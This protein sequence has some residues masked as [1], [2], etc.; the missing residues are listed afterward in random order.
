MSYIFWVWILLSQNSENGESK[1][2]TF[3]LLNNFQKVFRLKIVIYVMM[4]HCFLFLK[5]LKLYGI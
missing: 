4:K 2:V 5:T 3:I 1:D